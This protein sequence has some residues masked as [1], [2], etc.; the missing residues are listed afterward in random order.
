MSELTDQ[1]QR[2]REKLAA[3]KADGR[4]PF[5]RVRYDRTH[6][7]H[8][9]QE[10]FDDLDGEEVCVAGRVTAMRTMGKASFADLRDGSGRVQLFAR[11]N[12]LGEE[13]YGEFLDLDRGDVVGARGKVFRTRTGEV[14]V[15]VA[16]WE[17][18]AKALR[19]LPDKW[20][21]LRDVET[22]YRQRYV[23]LLVNERSRE[24][25]TARHHVFRAVRDVLEQRG[26]VEVE[27]PILQPIHGGAAALPFSTHHNALDMELF[28]RIAPELY[29]KRLVVAGIERVFEISRCF[30][31]EGISPRHNPEFTQVEAY[32]AYADYH[33]M[34][35]LMEQLVAQSC[36]AVHG[37]TQ[38]TYRDTEID[39]TPPWTRLGLL[40]AI[41]EHS[42]VD[43][44]VIETDEA[45]REAGREA[46]LEVEDD[47]TWGEVLDRLLDD[48]VQPRL[49]QPTLVMD[50][51]V[52][53]SPL[54]KRKPDDPFVAERFEPFIGGE[55]LGNAFSELNDP[56]D[57]RERFEA[58]ARQ[59]E[60]GDEEAH[61]FDEDYVR[62]LEYG[63][64]PTGG[65]GLGLDRLTM[66]LTDADNLRETIL[67]PLL[68]P[69]A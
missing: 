38:F 20:A 2:R 60:A 49:Q 68:R 29:L 26:F 51:P 59:R 16:E 17:L 54:A 25:I 62:A 30:R 58:Q 5:R 44:R 32:Q 21:G 63:L 10:S 28:L 14:S 52:R 18:L 23:D 9:V 34:M 65:L 35:D 39:V 19:P 22:R 6:L 41:E 42:G 37:G 50:Y 64:P 31:N 33:D 53:I 67:F 40:D 61:P 55:E 7:A 43:F 47:D 56:I 46:G 13:G 27:T 69:E 36:L 3:L 4:D 12:D 8:D 24:I 66:L 15:E 57:Q 48:R 11:R 45:A 1:E